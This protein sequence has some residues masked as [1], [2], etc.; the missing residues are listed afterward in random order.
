MRC[1]AGNTAP[2]RS[3]ANVTTGSFGS[4]G[5]GNDYRSRPI[6]LRAHCRAELVYAIQTGEMQAGAQ[7]CFRVVLEE[8]SDTKNFR[9]EPLSAYTQYPALTILSPASNTQRF[10]KG[11]EKQSGDTFTDLSGH[12]SFN[13]P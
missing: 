8:N 13:N 1:D 10:S 9:F 12:V 7:V 6:T 4:Q 11:V 2:L 3:S 5:M